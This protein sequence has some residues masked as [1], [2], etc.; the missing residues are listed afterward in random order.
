M[1]KFQNKQKKILKIKKNTQKK[2]CGFFFKME[3]FFLFGFDF[4]PKKKC[5]FEL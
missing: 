4:R 2:L 1:E 5:I 3:N